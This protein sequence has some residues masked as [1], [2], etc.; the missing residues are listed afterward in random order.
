[1]GSKQK[2]VSNVPWLLKNVQERNE[3]DEAY[4]IEIRNAVQLVVL[5]IA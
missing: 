3:A 5:P 4:V 2:R 1:M